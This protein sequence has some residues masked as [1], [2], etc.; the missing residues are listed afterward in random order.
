MSSCMDPAKVMAIVK[1][2]RL[3]VRVKPNARKS[4]AL[5]IEDSALYLAIAAPP[6]GGK[7]NAEVVR[8]LTKLLKRKATIKSGF[9]AKDKTVLIS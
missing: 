3:A 7:A 8:F 2:N 1:N 6:E 4:L 5:K 9:T